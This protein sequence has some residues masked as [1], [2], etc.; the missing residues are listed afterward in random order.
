MC[1]IAGLVNFDNSYTKTIK[2][3]LYHRGPD[4]QTHYQDR[5]L[6]LIHTR[7]SI[8]D[9]KNGNQPFKIDNYVIIFNGEIYNH[10]ELRKKLKKYICKTQSDTETLLALYIE[11]G[12]SAIEMIDGMFAFIIYDI[13]SNKLI[14]GRDRLGKKPIYYYKKNNQLFIS[15]ELNTLSASLPNLAVNNEAIASYLR[16]GFFSNNITPYRFI[17]E[18]TPGYLYEINLSS[19]QINKYQYFNIADQYL[20]PHN[21]NHEEALTKLDSIL[22]KSIKDRLLSSDLDVGTFLSSGIDSS[23]I[24][25]IASQYKKDIKTFTVKF[26]GIFDESVNARKTSEIFSTNHHELEISIDLKN[27]V[28]KILKAYGEPFMD[29]SAIPSFYVSQEAKK[30][31]TVVLNGDGADEIF[32]GYRRYIPAAHNWLKYAKYFSMLSNFLPISK[33]KMSYYNYFYRLIAMSSKDDFDLYLSSTNDIFEDFYRFGVQSTDE[34][35][36]KNILQISNNNLSTL[37]KS[38][39]LDSTFL[40]PNDLLKKMDIATMT[41]SLE[42]RSPFLSKYMLEWAPKLSDKEKIRGLKTKFILRDLAKQYSLNYLSKMPKR[43]FEAPLKKWVENDLKENIYDVVGSQNS[44]SKNFVNPKVINKL[45]HTKVNISGEKRAKILWTL[46]SLEVWNS[47]RAQEKY[48]TNERTD[49]INTNSDIEFAERKNILFL[50]TGLGLGGAERVVLDICKNINKDKFLVS[51]IGISSQNDLINQFY[52]NNIHVDVLNY[53]KAISKFLNS[54]IEISKHIKN[55]NVQ[56]VHAHMFHTLIIGFLIKIF[57]S[58]IRL[59][60]TPHN[61]FQSMKI[62]RLILWFLK[63]FRDY[64][65]I[66]SKESINYYHKKSAFIIPNGIEVNMYSNKNTI[67]KPFIF[68]IVG[69]LEK[70]KNHEF[71]INVVNELREF[72]FE[73]NIVGTGILEA[74]L[75]SQ[76]SQLNLNGKVHFLGASEDVPELLSQS[77]CLLL[78]SLWE[79][80]PIVLL[81]AAA[82]NI[83]VITTPVG[84]VPSFINSNEGYLVD[85]NK[86]KEA[87][88]EVITDY[89]NAKIK[90]NLLNKKVSSAYNIKKITLLYENLYKKALE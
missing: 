35:I 29:S 18:V 20:N 67:P 15:S 8:L 5:N 66:F 9:I 28:E 46:Y 74:S 61:S 45:L 25:A 47:S 62:R 76:V 4:A 19:L 37:S 68:I 86:F 42:A 57:N 32:A 51:V 17:K 75:K 21:I 56:I 16:V 72:D 60:F 24:V 13:A 70:M 26:Q 30:Y 31:V 83:P 38:L 82:A 55:H 77:H 3:S 12:D 44:Y 64:D 50:T 53:R 14:L 78:P 6:Q 88:I 22:H 73:L 49:I 65:T 84:S 71:L 58:K 63:P 52:K 10:L 23:L 11:L 79:A 89:K 2:K 39:I 27:D 90:S 54:L 1:G 33:N 7:L 81:E 69:R 36:K 59:I 41:N 85:L 87:M 34:E 40:L 43:G 48:N 80:F